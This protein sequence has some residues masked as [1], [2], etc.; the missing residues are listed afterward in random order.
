M[1]LKEIIAKLRNK[2]IDISSLTPD[3]ILDMESTQTVQ[4][5]IP[6]PIDIDSINH[7]RRKIE[8]VL[9]EN[10]TLKAMIKESQDTIKQF[11][12]A[13]KKQIDDLMKGFAEK[14]TASQA[15]ITTYETER[16]AKIDNDNQLKIDSIINKAIEEKRI[17]K[18][19]TELQEKYK[20]VLSAD[21]ETGES[22]ISGLPSLEIQ[23]TQ[24]TV[25]TS[26][27]QQGLGKPN[28]L[29]GSGVNPK[30]L[31]YVKN[32]VTLQ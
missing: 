20:K 19:N 6:N 25:N 5:P 21:I 17:P 30:I 27:Q 2:G 31:D 22:I 26:T 4:T 10:A 12:E 13:T 23:N 9:S 32:T 16:Q 3:D 14:E 28:T 15:L 8:D 11:Q 18:D 24:T 7:N 1:G 29:I